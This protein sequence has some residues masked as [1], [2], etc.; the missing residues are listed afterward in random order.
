[1]E[2]YKDFET[3][4]F[5]IVKNINTNIDLRNM[6]YDVDMVLN[7][8]NKIDSKIPNSYLLLC[9]YYGK[10]NAILMGIIIDKKYDLTI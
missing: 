7:K 10:N 4:R 3:C 2:Y 6:C 9:E 5:H 8:L 1:M